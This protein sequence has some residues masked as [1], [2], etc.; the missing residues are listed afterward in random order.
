MTLASVL[1]R[2]MPK[3]AKASLKQ[4]NGTFSSIDKVYETKSEETFA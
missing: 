4:N 2:T 3:H 1:A